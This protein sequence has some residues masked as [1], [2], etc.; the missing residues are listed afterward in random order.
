VAGAETLYHCG[1]L[2]IFS[3]SDSSAPR[4]PLDAPALPISPG[5]V[6][7]ALAALLALQPVTTDLYLP[8]LPVLTRSLNATVAAGQLTLSALLLAF[9]CSQLFW[10]PVSDRF[11]RRPVLLAGLSLY[12]VASIASAL[13]PTMVLLI[14]GRTVQGAAMGAV[15]MCARAIV[16]DLYTPLAGAR[17]M[18][19]GLSGLGI[20][21]CVSAPIGGLLTQWLGWRYAL[22]A[23]TLYAACT[24]A[25]IAL[26]L[27]ETLVQRNP[28]ALRPANV[29]RTWGMVLRSPT[30]WA[31][32]LLTAAS[33]GGLFAF[34]ATSSFVYMEVL[35]LSRMQYGLALTSMSAA[36]L[37]GTVVCRRLLAR[38]GLLRTV[39]IAAGLSG[40]SGILLLSA[41]LL[42]WHSVAALLPPFWLFMMG[43]GIHQPCGQSGSVGPFPQAAGVASALNGFVMM[44]VAFVTGLFLGWAHNG[45]IWPLVGGISFWAACLPLIGWTLVQR[46]GAAK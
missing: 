33:Y 8:A 36:Y 46:Y 29:L 35:G 28:Q 19:R 7:L 17:A 4:S 20:V 21:A 30:F 3:M 13:A 44:V 43:Q 11:G 6:V 39:A 38:F 45:T 27:P 23:L 26:R 32:S 25:L 31:F 40:S 2:L 12:V 16:R 34:L 15:V 41:A 9:G 1:P 5:L 42:G 10:G 22:L 37:L 14:A 18:S 24:L